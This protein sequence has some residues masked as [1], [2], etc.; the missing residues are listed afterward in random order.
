MVHEHNIPSLT[1][2]PWGRGGDHWSSVPLSEAHRS[3]L[4]RCG[5][6]RDQFSFIIDDVMN[7]LTY[8]IDNNLYRFPN[9]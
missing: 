1:A 6:G 8:G 7:D 2:A 5:P 4:L 3:T 9:L